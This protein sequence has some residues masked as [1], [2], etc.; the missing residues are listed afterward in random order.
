[1]ALNFVT[2]GTLPER[3]KYHL[4]CPLFGAREH[5]LII[6]HIAGYHV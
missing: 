3:D 2:V 5:T 1:M 4:L 6:R